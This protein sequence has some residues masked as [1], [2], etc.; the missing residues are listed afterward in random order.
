[1]DVDILAQR[2]EQW[3]LAEREARLYFAG[4]YSIPL[5]DVRI[6]YAVMLILETD[7]H[8][9]LLKLEWTA[10][11]IIELLRDVDFRSWADV[12]TIE[13]SNSIIPDDVPRYFTEQKIKFR[14]EIW[15]IYKYDVDPFPFLPHA[16][17]YSDNLKLDL[18]DGTFYRNRAAVGNLRKKD[19]IAFRQL[20]KYVE[21][22]E[23]IV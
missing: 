11:R 4:L 14:G 22:P 15:K 3:T 23:M 2:I 1:M 19:L 20:V 13:L 8:L 12:E 21:L 16:H 10:E 18:R 17:N 6:Q 9:D 5:A 7:N